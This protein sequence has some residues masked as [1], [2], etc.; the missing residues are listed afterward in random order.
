MYI[1]S[2]SYEYNDIIFFLWNIEDHI[3]YYFFNLGILFF[4]VGFFIKLSL[5]PFNYWVID[6]YENT[7]LPVTFFLL[8]F[9]KFIFTI[10]FCLT[11][12]IIFFNNNFYVLLILFVS[13]ISFIINNIIALYQIKLK[14]LL[15]CSSLAN[16]PFFFLPIYIKT[17]FSFIT[18]YSFFIVYFFNLYGV[19]IFMIFF[20]NWSGKN[21]FFKKISA[22]TG[23]V[24]NNKILSY[25]ISSFFLSLAG[26][27][28]FSGFFAK[29]YFLNLL[30]ANNLFYLFLLLSFI[31]LIT[32]FYYLRLVKLIFQNKNYQ[33]KLLLFKSFWLLMLLVL[34]FLINIFFIFY[35]Q[36]IFN[37]LIFFVLNFEWIYYS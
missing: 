18:F 1:Y 8:I 14:K 12:L 27:P 20:Y 15:I 32:V 33:P 37:F 23:F 16:A 17:F 26:L 6:V 22:L 28:P 11:L 29:F 31:N 7:S 25:I 4:L 19:F 10:F 24:K 3:N 5:F 21:Y 9:P 36:V 2:G 34:L 30:M 13:L 35:F